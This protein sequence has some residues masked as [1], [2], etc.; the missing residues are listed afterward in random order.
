MGSTYILSIDQGTTGSTAVLIDNKG[1]WIASA[2]KDFP[3]IFPR[4][5]WVE[6]DPEEIWNSVVGSIR[7]VLD[8][9]RIDARAIATIGI[10]NQ[11]E[12]TL[13]WDSK[14]GKP[15]CNAIVWQC[16]RTSK[17][18]EKLKNLGMARKIRNTTGLVV[19]PYFSA[20]KIAW[21]LKN[22]PE[23]KQLLKMGRLRVGTVDSF[24][25]WRLTGGKEHKTEVSNASR[26]MLMN[27]KTLDWDREMLNLFKIPKSVLPTIHSSADQFGVTSGLD[28]LPNDIPINGILGDQQ[29]ALFGQACL[30]PGSIKCTFG[31]G[32][33]ILLNTGNKL[34]FSK[35]GMIT[36]VAWRLNGKVAY[37]LEGGAFICGAAVQWLRD[38]LKVISS[39]KEIE[40]LASQV[41]STEGVE[42]IPALTGLG[43]PHWKP[44]ARGVLSG[45]SRGT[46]GAHIARATLEAM[47][48]QN[49]DIIGAMEKDLGKKISSLNV[50]GGAT[51]NNLLMQLQSDYLGKKVVRPRIIETTAYGAGL[52]A[53]M[54]V[55]I[56]KNTQELMG[57]W[58]VERTFSPRIGSRA[59]SM[60]LKAWWLAIKNMV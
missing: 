51:E 45:L 10:T 49:V 37:A 46:T 39:T 30:S 20:T 53:G 44:E 58:G 9:T 22:V 60:R 57:L 16:R 47:A 42:F 33:F 4:S 15:V 25:L 6:H 24:L 41:S 35:H 2:D 28:F 31:T 48:L 55:G 13:A 12:T 32:S 54:G 18:C 56:W 17:A 43:A 40:A 19:D 7:K 3:Q 34:V 5:G 23:A 59:R 36:T 29:A 21:I 26:T 27:L 14:T 11:R 8:Q 1:E 52:M 50:D 38:G